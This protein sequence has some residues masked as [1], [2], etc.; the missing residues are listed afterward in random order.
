MVGTVLRVCHE[1][2]AAL[3]PRPVRSAVRDRCRVTSDSSD[4][5][6]TDCG[7]GEA[8]CDCC[9]EPDAF[10]HSHSRFAVSS[11]AGAIVQFV[12][13]NAVLLLRPQSTLFFLF[14]FARRYHS[15][16]V[17]KCMWFGLL[18]SFISYRLIRRLQ[19]FNRSWCVS[20]ICFN[21]LINLNFNFI[22][23]MVFAI[24]L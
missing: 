24:R 4:G 14:P 6:C 11:R 15:S 3:V 23:V 2:D 8:D 5:V 10:Q 17:L 1:W 21:C 22:T 18:F 13:H 19:N 20:V 12:R 7:T 9:S 16:T